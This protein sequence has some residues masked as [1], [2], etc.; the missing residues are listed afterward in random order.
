[1]NR[2]FKKHHPLNA[3]ETIICLIAEYLYG[4]NVSDSPSVIKQ[5][6]L[7]IITLIDFSLYVWRTLMADFTPIDFLSTCGMHSHTNMQFN[8]LYHMFKTINLYVLTHS[9]CI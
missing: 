6:M 4:Y 9:M 8:T 7:K 1:M 2:N 3:A 5:N